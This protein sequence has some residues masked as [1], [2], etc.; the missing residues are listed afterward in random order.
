MSG[1]RISQGCFGLP[2]ASTSL[3]F[4][5]YVAA[6]V[7]NYDVVGVPASVVRCRGERGADAPT[8]G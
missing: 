6:S 7:S 4:P 1:T 5:D 8:F 2:S 3:N